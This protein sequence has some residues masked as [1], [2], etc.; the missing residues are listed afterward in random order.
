MSSGA[1]ANL[2]RCY[3][4][5]IMSCILWNR[6]IRSDRNKGKRHSMR[7]TSLSREKPDELLEHEVTGSSSLRFDPKRVDVL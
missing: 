5:I 2:M 6:P 4:C 7:G 3:G 1:R